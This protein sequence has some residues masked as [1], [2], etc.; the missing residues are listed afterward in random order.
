MHSRSYFAVPLEALFDAV[1]TSHPQWSSRQSSITWLD[2]LEPFAIGIWK[3]SARK[4]GLAQSPAQNPSIVDCRFLELTNGDADRVRDRSV[5]HVEARS[6][7]DCR[8]CA[9]RRSHVRAHCHVERRF[10]GDSRC[11]PSYRASPAAA[12]DDR[13]IA[14]DFLVEGS[15][16]P[17]DG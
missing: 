6:R 1:V 11:D 8:C 9:G 2:H 17:L 10:P 16:E 5:L 4:L 14:H 15:G 7:G 12:S 13:P 3:P